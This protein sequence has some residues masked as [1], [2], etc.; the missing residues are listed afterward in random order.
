M[1]P[2]QEFDLLKQALGLIAWI[3]ALLAT[4]IHNA[5][6]PPTPEKAQAGDQKSAPSK[7]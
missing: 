5:P 2:Q 1:T 6:T 3:V 4:W 7:H